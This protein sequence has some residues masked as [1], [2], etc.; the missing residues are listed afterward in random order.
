MFRSLRQ[1]L[2]WSQIFPLLLALPLMGIL[3]IYTLEGQILI[4]QLAKNLVSHA[5]LLAEIS[6]AEF[7]LWGDPI[8]FESMISRVQLD[9]DIKVMFLDGHGILLFSSDSSDRSFINT[10]PALPGIPQALNGKETA[11]TNYSI[12][13]LSNVTVDIYEPVANASREVIGIVRLTYRIGSIYDI[14]DQ[15]RWQILVALGVGLVLSVVIGT[16][17]AIGISR[18]V[19]EVTDAIYGLATGQRREPVRENG[20]QELRSQAQA[21]NFLVEQLHDLETSRRQ[22]L[23]NIVHE[24]GRPLGALRSAIH[25]LSKGAAD[26]PVLL[27]D[28]TRGMDDETQRL[29]FLL[30]ELANLY[31]KVTGSL[32]LDR[33][34]VEMTN[35]LKGVLIPWQAAANEKHLDWQEQLPTTLP[36]ISIDAQRMAQA[37][38]N[39]A[40]N[41][42]KYTPSGGKVS[43]SAGTDQKTFWLKIS[44]T[45]PG[46]LEIEREKIFLPFYRGDTGRR[47]KQGMGLGLTIARE[48]VEAHG[49]QLSMESSLGQGSEFIITL[50]T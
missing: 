7:E 49:G 25:A 17:L 15:L 27:A 26:D 11:L 35:W 41:A 19:R 40:S 32:E 44:D 36:S 1:R 21:V 50:P 48:L 43:I 24:L 5:R 37:V 47:I 13:N 30:D 8:L 9:S 28:L 34:P 42:V 46:I 38:G 45:G 14:F 29:Q 6:S 3:L 2:I 20:P 4:P 33:Q 39:L 18:P 31:D 23:A 10:M 22:L 16:W 12:I